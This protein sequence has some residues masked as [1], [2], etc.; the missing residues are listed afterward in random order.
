MFKEGDRAYN[1]KHYEAL[2]EVITDYIY[3]YWS[4][5]SIKEHDVP[6]DA[7][8][9]ESKSFIFMSDDAMTSDKLVILIHGSG[10]VRAGQWARRYR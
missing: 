5:K 8:E 7:K 9:D 4:K 6:V 10:V 1:Q 2:G 3:H